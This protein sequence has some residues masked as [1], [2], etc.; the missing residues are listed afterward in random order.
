MKIS[1]KIRM[2]HC[3]TSRH[4]RNLLRDLHETYYHVEDGECI[5][6]VRDNPIDNIRTFLDIA[7]HAIGTLNDIIHV[8][9]S[10]V[11][12]EIEMKKENT[13]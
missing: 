11:K 1:M 2:Y 3:E 7:A 9:L 8:A 13:D 12:N 10:E 4:V 5:P 6:N